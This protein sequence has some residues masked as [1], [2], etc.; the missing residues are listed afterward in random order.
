MFRGLP[1][2]SDPEEISAAL[3]ELNFK[4]IKVNQMSMG[5]DKRKIPLFLIQIAQTSNYKE[6]FELNEI[7]YSI[8]TVEPLK[9]K[10]MF[11]NAALVSASVTVNLVATSNPGALNALAST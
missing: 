8:I 4:I 6:I 3:N 1:I 9:N 2:N 11:F 10:Q 7:L 5:T